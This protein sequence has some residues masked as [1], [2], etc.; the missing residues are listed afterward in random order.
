[1]MDWM[2]E[3][4][5]AWANEEVREAPTEESEAEAACADETAAALAPDRVM[6]PE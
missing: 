3:T 1:M 4:E 5:E 2:L 6:A